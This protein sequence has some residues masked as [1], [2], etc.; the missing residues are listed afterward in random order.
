MNRAS[1]TDKLCLLP[2]PDSAAWKEAQVV[3]NLEKVTKFHFQSSSLQSGQFDLGLKLTVT[4]IPIVSSH[5]TRKHL[6]PLK[7]TN[8]P[9][10]V[11]CPHRAG[12]LQV[13]SY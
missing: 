9:G 5:S 2:G 3:Y 10:S 13:R 12:I 1:T 7:L 4:C 8:V 6:D 11:G